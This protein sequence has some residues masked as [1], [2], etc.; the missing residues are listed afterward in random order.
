MA[1]VCYDWKWWYFFVSSVGSLFGGVLLILLARAVLYFLFKKRKR[2]EDNV[3]I[4]RSPGGGFFVAEEASSG[5]LQA[6]FSDLLSIHHIP[7]RI[8]TVA[9]LV[10]SLVSIVVYLRDTYEPIEQC[11]VELKDETWF[12]IDVAANVYFF[13]HFLLRF[14]AADDKLSMW[15]SLESIV[16]YF[17]VPPII[18]AL[19]SRRYWLGFRFMRI[20]KI[21]QVKEV[22][23]V[24]GLVKPGLVLQLSIV[25]I[26]FFTAW[27]T[28]SGFFHLVENYGDPW[29]N[30]SSRNPLS[31]PTTLYF[32]MVTVSTVGYGDISPTTALGRIFFVLFI[33]GGLALFATYTPMFIDFFNFMSPYERSLK[34][35][36]K[37]KHVIVCG[38][39]TE[40]TVGTFLTDF[41]HQDRADQSTR[42]VFLHPEKPSPPIKTFLKKLSAR[43]TYLKGS[44]LKSVDLE[45]VKAKSAAACIILA[46]K[47]SPDPVAEDSANILR[48]VSVKNYS[49]DVRTIVQ[50]IEVSSKR[51]LVNIPNFCRSN[52]DD[53]VCIAELKLGLIGQSCLCPGFSTL[54]ANLTCMRGDP[55]VSA[56]DGRLYGQWELDYFAGASYELY[57]TELPP[58]FVNKTFK[59][60]VKTCYEDY[61]LLLFALQVQGE[62]KDSAP[63]LLFNPRRSMVIQPK[64]EGFF[65]AKD[66]EEVQKLSEYDENTTVMPNADALEMQGGIAEDNTPVVPIQR[67][68][69]AF[70]RLSKLL[71]RKK[72]ILRLASSKKLSALPS[73]EDS[74]ETYCG[75]EKTYDEAILSSAQ[76]MEL[77]DHVIICTFGTKKSQTLGLEHLILP[78]RRTCLSRG[79]LKPVVLLGDGKYLRKEWQNLKKFESIGI[80]EGS[81]LEREDLQKVSLNYASMC[82]ILSPGT[83]LS[84]DDSLPIS[85]NDKECILATLNLKGMRFEEMESGPVVSLD[86]N[87]PSVSGSRA[88][89]RQLRDRLLIDGNDV[90]IITELVVDSNVEF[91]EQEDEDDPTGQLY[92]TAPFAH[93]AAMAVSVLDSFMSATFYNP[94]ILAV[95][96]TLITGQVPWS[97]LSASERGKSNYSGETGNC[98]LGQLYLADTAYHSYASEGR[99]Y[100]ELMFDLLEKDGMLCLGI[101][102]SRDAADPC[103]KRYVITAPNADFKLERFDKVYVLM[104]AFKEPADEVDTDNHGG[105]MGIQPAEPAAVRPVLVRPVQKKDVM[106]VDE[107]DPISS[108]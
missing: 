32:T 6:W 75:A 35:N 71:H 106:N 42:V 13:I 98:R 46:N 62:G 93:G 7:G 15:V 73:D 81:P 84:S 58:F 37:K 83:S 41:M 3:V 67:P 102:R 47:N 24:T 80:V 50:L 70:A 2:S 38:H 12:I 108:V 16:D 69:S 97:H 29:N 19:A 66:E 91:L 43:V 17:T 49:S 4:E 65:M 5:G 39:I 103:S 31:Y 57:S 90:P 95:V 107:N 74:C 82:V 28:A 21:M 27:L 54:L 26:N 23:Q 53:V 89:R 10:V 9:T 8:I 11:D 63:R 1:V 51:H 100:K 64:T 56:T 99:R 86:P 22:L 44:I 30:G 92:R 36:P 59:Q 48:V 52:L 78:L 105:H 77:C 40:E 18:V 68:V 25:G 79:E 61:G 34:E 14:L 72:K 87:S 76:R 45:R 101:Y 33:I 55:G 96:K 88:Q 94:D 85:F 20:L 60:A 104:P